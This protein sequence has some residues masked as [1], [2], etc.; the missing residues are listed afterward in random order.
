MSVGGLSKKPVVARCCTIIGFASSEWDDARLRQHAREAIEA[1]G[2]LDEELWSTLEQQ[3]TYVQGDYRDAAS[4]EALKDRLGGAG[5]HHPLYYLAVPP[6]LFD[7]V[8]DGS[9]AING[10]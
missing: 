10:V 3:I 2:E 6:A 4:Y 9:F 1:K 7:D 8:V 5:C